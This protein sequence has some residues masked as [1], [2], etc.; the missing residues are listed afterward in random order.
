MAGPVAHDSGCKPCRP[1]LQAYVLEEWVRFHPEEGF[2]DECSRSPSKRHRS[3]P[4]LQ[5]PGADLDHSSNATEA[6]HSSAYELWD[7]FDGMTAPD[8]NAREHGDLLGLCSPQPP[9]APAVE[10]SSHATCRGASH[11]TNTTWSWHRGWNHNDSWTAQAS[12]DV[13]SPSP[14]QGTE[15]LDNLQ[16]H[17]PQRTPRAHRDQSSQSWQPHVANEQPSLPLR[18]R[19]VQSQ[20]VLMTFSPATVN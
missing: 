10:A 4:R 15:T 13:A 5:S 14:W 9:Q 2:R 18:R 17:D 11:T 19:R 6:L 20:C 1:F 8:I 16:V 7:D 3:R 12:R